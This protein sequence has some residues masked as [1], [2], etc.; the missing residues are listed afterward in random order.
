MEAQRTVK[1]LFE[2]NAAEFVGS[3][4]GITNGKEGLALMMAENEDHPTRLNK[5]M[6]RVSVNEADTGGG[7]DNDDDDDE[8]EDKGAATAGLTCRSCAITFVR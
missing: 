7:G 3:I 6:A 4:V 2:L 5:A 8:E 1:S